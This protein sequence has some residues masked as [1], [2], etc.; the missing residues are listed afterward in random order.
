MAHDQVGRLQEEMWGSLGRRQEEWVS[1]G[2]LGAEAGQPLEESS[3]PEAWLS[4][5]G[6]PRQL[7]DPLHRDAPGGGDATPVPGTGRGTAHA[8]GQHRRLEDHQPLPQ[9]SRYV[10]PCKNPP[11]R[12]PQTIPW[13]G[14]TTPAHS[15]CQGQ[16][17]GRERALGWAASWGR[18]G[19]EGPG[20]Y[21]QGNKLQL[22]SCV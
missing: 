19:W 11:I 4:A 20:S 1:R 8:P 22:N 12:G 10:G 17:L 2:R 21:P 9:R 18:E 3:W 7:P 13:V 5:L 14:T 15:F 6:T 16:A